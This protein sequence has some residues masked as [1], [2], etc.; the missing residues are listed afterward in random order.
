MIYADVPSFFG[1]GLWFLCL[2]LKGFVGCTGKVL[3][4][5]F[6]CFCLTTT[7]H[8]LISYPLSDLDS[9]QKL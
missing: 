4:D 1:L 8:T 7:I 5:S 3:C 9:Q 2:G 6:H